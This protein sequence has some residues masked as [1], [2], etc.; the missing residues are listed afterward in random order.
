[1]NQLSFSPTVYEMVKRYEFVKTK[2]PEVVEEQFQLNNMGKQDAN[3]LGGELNNDH[4]A[5]GAV[6][7]NP[8]LAFTK[9]QL[10]SID[11]IPLPQESMFANM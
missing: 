1:M 9:R 10:D 7:R 3:L 2:H 6:P 5:S 8:N 11:E 4:L